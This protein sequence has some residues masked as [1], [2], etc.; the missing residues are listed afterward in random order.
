M[1]TEVEVILSIFMKSDKGVIFFL[2]RGSLKRL[3]RAYEVSSPLR[4]KR[5]MGYLLFL[6]HFVLPQ[7]SS[8]IIPECIKNT[9]LEREI[10]FFFFVFV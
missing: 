8:V 1:F 3:H 10:E 5:R 4:A 6:V 2:F 9:L 7:F